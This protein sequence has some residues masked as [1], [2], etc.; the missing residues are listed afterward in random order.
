VAGN[1][2]NGDTAA[3]LRMHDAVEI[4]TGLSGDCSAINLLES[5]SLE[6]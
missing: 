5:G 4:G 1:I 3:S 6:L 2:E